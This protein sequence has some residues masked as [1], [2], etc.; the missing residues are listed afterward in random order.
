M[1]FTLNMGVIL[2]S[3]TSF[4]IRSISQKIPTIGFRRRI[5]FNGLT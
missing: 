1:V 3:E 5:E 4:N 2:S